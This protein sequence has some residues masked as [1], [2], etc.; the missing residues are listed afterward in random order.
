MSPA[1]ERLAKLTERHADAHHGEAF[2]WEGDEYHGTPQEAGVDVAM[3][4]MGGRNSKADFMLSCSRE[5]FTD[6]PSEG[7]VI[8]WR[9]GSW[10][11]VKVQAP[12]DPFT[13]ILH[14]TMRVR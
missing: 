8:L 10:K 14:V 13:V 6:V 9:G 7:A 3:L 12:G 1:F 4:E 11:V 2:E 5:Q